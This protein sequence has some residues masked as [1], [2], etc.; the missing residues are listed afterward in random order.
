MIDP[1]DKRPDTL[2]VAQDKKDI[3]KRG[4]IMLLFVIAFGLGQ[5]LLYLVA[6][7]QFIW[8]IAKHAPNQLLAEFGNSLARW[9]AGTARFLS[10]AT[11]DKPF[12]WAPWPKAE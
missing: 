3:W 6:V 7:A 1:I 8:L 11:D 12:P 9:L 10:C 4:L 2:N 5:S